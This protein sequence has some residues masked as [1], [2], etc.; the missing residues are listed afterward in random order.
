MSLRMPSRL[1]ADEW[2]TLTYW[3]AFGGR[4]ALERQP[5]HVDDRV[6]RRADFVAH[7]R[8]ERS[9]RPIRLHRLF[10]RR[11]QVAMRR[12][13]RRDRIVDRAAELSEFTAAR[14]PKPVRASRSPADTLRAVARIGRTSRRNSASPTSQAIRKQSSVADRQEAEVAEERR[15]H[16]GAIGSQRNAERDA[17]A[18]CCPRNSSG[19]ATYRRSTPSRPAKSPALLPAP[20]E[21]RRRTVPQAFPTYLS[22]STDRYWTMPLSSRTVRTVLG[23]KPDRSM[24][25]GTQSRSR[26]AHTTDVTVPELV[27]DGLREIE[28]RLARCRFGK[29]G[30]GREVEGVPGPLEREQSAH[31][32]LADRAARRSPALAGRAVGDEHVVVE[33]I[34][35]QRVDQ[36]ARR[37]RRQRDDVRIGREHGRAGERRA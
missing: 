10:P 37:R 30:P 15:V 2:A 24:N 29:K 1:R 3:C 17:A 32:R 22:R 35:A 7:H 18:R 14:R 16:G 11:H 19:S 31:A 28:A 34:V 9:L 21:R 8:E 26:L 4:S 6:H 23:G 27:H 5:V 33:A 20:L 13:L 25:P 12:L 36:L